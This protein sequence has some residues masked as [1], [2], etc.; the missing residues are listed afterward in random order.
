MWCSLA[1]A[2]ANFHAHSEDVHIPE[3][4]NLV[5]VGVNGKKDDPDDIRFLT[6]PLAEAIM[7]WE[8]RNRVRLQGSV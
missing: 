3:R 5:H 1:C 4:N 8:G 7:E 6:T 2:E